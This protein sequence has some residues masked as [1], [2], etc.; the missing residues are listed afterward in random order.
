MRP[1]TP[2]SD[3]S[4]AEV[5]AE[6]RR[7]ESEQPRAKGIRALENE[8]RMDLLNVREAD[9]RGEI[10]DAEEIYAAMEGRARR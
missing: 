8:E 7:I 5:Q 4:Y 10:R 6:K 2:V 9:L 1:G 3:M